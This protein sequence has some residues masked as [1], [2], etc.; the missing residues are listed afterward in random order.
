MSRAPV[1]KIGDWQVDGPGCR[2]E[3]DG[4]RMSLEPKVM[5]LLLLLADRQGSVVGRETLLSALWPGMVVGEDTLP[6]TVSKLRSALADDVRQPAYIETIPKR[7]YRLIA[8]VTRAEAKPDRRGGMSARWIRVAT[9]PAVLV[10]ALLWFGEHGDETAPSETEL[11]VNRADDFY[12]LFTQA[13]NAAAI[14]LYERVIAR[15]PGNARA[16]AGLANAL[17]QRIIRWPEG[18][19]GASTLGEA[20]ASGLTDTPRARELLARA[21]QLARRAVKLAPHDA[22]AAKALGLVYAASG[23]LDDARGEYQRAVAMD[24]DAWEPLIN[25]GEL[26]NLDGDLPRAI[27]YYIEGYEIMQRMYALE[28]QRVGP[29]HAPLGVVIGEAYE[30]MGQAQ[31]AEIWYRRILLLSPYQPDATAHLA[32]ILA[33]SGDLREALVL[34]RNLL[35]A[36]SSHETCDELLDQTAGA[37]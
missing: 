28:P 18:G 12:M 29:W 31:E 5:D 15:E 26:A 36:G 17:V 9:V 4:G 13:D 27:E 37:P 7:G 2:I 16:Q 20:I 3:R 35:A 8:D 14:D 10:A 32:E 24:G 19:S 30:D 6:R 33:A 1:L 22:Q 23:R 21:E 25:L 11:L 34:C